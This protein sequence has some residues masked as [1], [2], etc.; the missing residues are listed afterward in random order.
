ME[1]ISPQRRGARRDDPSFFFS[2]A[3]SVPLAKRAVSYCG[4]PFEM[5][6]PSVGEIHMS[7]L[8]TAWERRSINASETATALLFWVDDLVHDSVTWMGHGLAS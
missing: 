4:F 8:R 1:S 5:L 3:F 2:S 7:G 6:D